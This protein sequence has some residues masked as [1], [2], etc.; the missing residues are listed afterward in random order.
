MTSRT[1]QLAVRIRA[2]LKVRVDAAVDA[3]KHSRDPSFTLREA[4]D[5]ALTHWVQSMENRYNEGQP[6]PP[7]AGGLDAGRPRRRTHPTEQEP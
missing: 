5:E 2:D 1:R 6:W 3:L 7:P 4:V